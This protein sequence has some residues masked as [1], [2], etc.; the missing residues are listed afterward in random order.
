MGKTTLWSAAIEHA[1]RRSWRVLQTRPT[2]AEATFAYAGLGDI[3][4][5]VPDG[6][7][8]DL[9]IPQRKALRVALLREE[10][11]GQNPDPRAVAVAC[12]NTLRSLSAAGHLVIAVDDIQWL[13]PASAQAMAFTMRRLDGDSVRFL[14][15]R[16]V[17]DR[18]APS[19]L[20]RALANIA[21]AQIEV[22]PIAVGAIER[23]RLHKR[24]AREMLGEALAQFEQL[25]ARLWTQAAQAEL[26]RIGGRVASPDALTPTEARVAALV[27][28][29]RTNREVGAILVVSERTVEGHLSRIYAKVGV[30]S[31]AELA[32]RLTS[33]VIPEA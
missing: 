4:E 1:L 7:L 6:A 12:L 2:D 5:S 16:R 9:P 21:H 32:H 29:G 8:A 30:R 28:E 10:P 13:D 19:G 18:T 31:R 22:G 33:D 24:A 17:D 20:D 3:L 26:A 14:L 27:A 23:R 15:A 11:E 25:G